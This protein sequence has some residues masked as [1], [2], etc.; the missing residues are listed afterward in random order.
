MKVM[1]K[2]FYLSINAIKVKKGKRNRIVLSLKFVKFA[3]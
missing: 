1:I 2:D 3:R